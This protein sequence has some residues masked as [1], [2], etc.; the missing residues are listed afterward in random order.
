MLAASSLSPSHQFANVSLAKRESTAIAV[1]QAANSYL[2]ATPIGTETDVTPDSPHFQGDPA[3][4]AFANG[5][6]VVVWHDLTEADEE[7][8]TDPTKAGIF[9]QVYDKSGNKLGGVIDVSQGDPSLG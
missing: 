4:A 8:S 5:N 7:L 9:A 3:I 2:P 1:P 6:Y